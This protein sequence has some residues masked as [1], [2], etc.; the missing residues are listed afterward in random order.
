MENEPFI[1]SLPYSK[2]NSPWCPAHARD[3]H[4]RLEQGTYD[5][6]AQQPAPKNSDCGHV[7]L[8]HAALRIRALSRTCVD[9]ARPRCCEQETLTTPELLNMLR[10]SSSFE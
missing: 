3:V 7:P 8:T 1:S 6:G 10:R 9:A 5:Q 2:L 4:V